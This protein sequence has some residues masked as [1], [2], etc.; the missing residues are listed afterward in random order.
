MLRK[1]VLRVNPLVYQKIA[2]SK[3]LKLY[4]R[5]NFLNSPKSYE[6]EHV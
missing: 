1:V 2:K 6:T 4:I 5:P 3:N